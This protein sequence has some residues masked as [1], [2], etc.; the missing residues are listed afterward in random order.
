MKKVFNIHSAMILMQN[1]KIESEVSTEKIS[2][3]LLMRYL[4]GIEETETQ[5]NYSL[6]EVKERSDLQ[7]QLTSLKK[8]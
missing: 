2:T 1:P 3:S 5:I 4:K 7:G 8:L 6:R